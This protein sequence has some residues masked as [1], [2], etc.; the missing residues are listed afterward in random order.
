MG[1]S[2]E[3]LET[4]PPFLPP[5]LVDALLSPLLAA[6]VAGWHTE[7]ALK[8]GEENLITDAFGENQKTEPRATTTTTTEVQEIMSSSLRLSQI[9]V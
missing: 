9:I 1:C 5:A 3:G 7:S 4:A 8:K 6:A 2:D